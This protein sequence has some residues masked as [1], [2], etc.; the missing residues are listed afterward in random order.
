MEDG[1]RKED[2]YRS[3]KSQHTAFDRRVQM[4]FRKPYLTEEEELEVKVLKK[5]KL[6]L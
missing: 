5:K 2:I 1:E 6:Y 3:A 4:L